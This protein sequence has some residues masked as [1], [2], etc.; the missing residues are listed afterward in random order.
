MVFV[1]GKKYNSN[2][3]PV[4][5][6]FNTEWFVGI[7]TEAGIGRNFSV[8]GYI[9]SGDYTNECIILHDGFRTVE[10]AEKWLDAKLYEWGLRLADPNH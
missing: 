4:E 7:S 9:H 10:E 5:G 1:K 8:C 3:K 6:F 2:I